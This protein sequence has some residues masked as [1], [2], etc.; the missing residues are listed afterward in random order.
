[1]RMMLYGYFNVVEW[2][3]HSTF[4]YRQ[5]HTKFKTRLAGYRSTIVLW[6]LVG[7]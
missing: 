4:I 3:V 1:M 7:T 5:G 6:F 2:I